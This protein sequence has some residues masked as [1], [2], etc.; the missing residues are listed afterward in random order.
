M[1]E[2]G[3]VSVHETAARF[4]AERGD[5]MTLAREGEATAITLKGKRVPGTTVPVGNS[6]EQQQFRV[7]ISVAELAA[8]A[9]AV[10]VPSSST[11]TITVD[12][13]PR[14]I[15]DS[16]PLGDAGRVAL[17]ELEVAG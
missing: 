3:A 11:D 5:T 6:A 1:A 7:K 10:K 16:R 17:Y 8:S 9:W 4:V 12:G 14:M 2:S 15:L 13:V